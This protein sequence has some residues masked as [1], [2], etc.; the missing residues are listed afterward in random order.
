MKKEHCPFCHIIDGKETVDKIYEDDLVMAFLHIAPVNKGHTIIVPRQHYAGMSAV[1][2]KSLTRLMECAA[3]I[4][5]AAM[6]AVKA[7]GYNLLVS[8]GNCAGQVIQHAA[9]EAIPRFT[10]DAVI[11]PSGTIPYSNK[12]EKKE[13]LLKMKNR[14]AY[15]L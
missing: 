8:N 1:D 13:I 5:T 2:K 11:L 10:D 12:D 6:R 9:I 14:I 15:R 7:E 3:I 4:A